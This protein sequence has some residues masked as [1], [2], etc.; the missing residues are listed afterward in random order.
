M[1]RI[2]RD[3]EIVEMTEE[4]YAATWAQP[5]KAERKTQMLAV[6]AGRRWQAEVGGT[7]IGGVVPLKTDEVTQTKL[8]AA[9]VKAQADP[10]FSISNWKVAPCVFGPLSNAEIIA[11]GNAMTAHIQLCFDNEAA[12]SAQILAADTHAALDAINIETG[13][14]S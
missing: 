10:G 4:E 2:A 3:G 7:M 12:L 9:Y 8:T 6:L 11:A 13:W 5:T 1:I 14:P